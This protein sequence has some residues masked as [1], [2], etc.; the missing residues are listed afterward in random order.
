MHVL[1]AICRGCAIS[2]ALLV[3]NSIVHADALW[4]FLSLPQDSREV[5]SVLDRLEHT[6]HTSNWDA[7]M[8][9]D[10]RKQALCLRAFAHTITGRPVARIDTIPDADTT[11][12]EVENLGFV[13]LYG[14]WLASRI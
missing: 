3:K 14:A 13:A 5:F 7:W 1:Q 6:M 9:G 8:L 4:R 11:W 12:S 2:V 10:A